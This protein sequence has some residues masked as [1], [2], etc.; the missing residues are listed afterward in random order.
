MSFRGLFPG[1]RPPTSFPCCAPTIVV[2]PHQTGH[3]VEK[4]LWGGSVDKY[5][6]YNVDMADEG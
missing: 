4:G 6:T 3:L 1:P 5:A 2:T